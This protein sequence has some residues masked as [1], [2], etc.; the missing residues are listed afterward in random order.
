M[1]TDQSN[2]AP[3]VR[4]I[5]TPDDARQAA[6]DAA[7]HRAEP[8]VPDVFR[9]P[10][11]FV[12]PRRNPD[13]MCRCCSAWPGEQC[14]PGC[15]TLMS[16]EDAQ[17]YRDSVLDR[18]LAELGIEVVPAL[19]SPPR[20]RSPERTGMRP[21]RARRIARAVLAVAAIVLLV[22]LGTMW[23]AHLGGAR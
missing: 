4:P 19:T 5:W 15:L 17:R 8:G 11:R 2:P 18:T 13:D 23:A 1:S 6:A 21:R 20:G 16:P 10:P 14:E 12:P 3:L 9:I 22:A 7:H